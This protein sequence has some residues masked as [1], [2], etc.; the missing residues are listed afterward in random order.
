M[1]AVP[2]RLERS[3]QAKMEWRL[4][5]PLPALEGLEGLEPLPEPEPTMKRKQERSF[6]AKLEWR[7]DDPVEA[8]LPDKSTLT[9]KLPS[10]EDKADADEYAGVLKAR[11]DQHMKIG[12][13]WEGR[14]KSLLFSLGS[15]VDL[16]KLDSPF[17]SLG[18]EVQFS[19]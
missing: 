14:I 13:L 2:P 5:D 8:S 9:E 10:P 12:L 1:A 16:R 18:L 7:L 3:F 19:S 6:Q 11:L 4:D 17:R 15:G